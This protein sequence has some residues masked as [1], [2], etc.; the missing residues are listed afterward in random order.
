LGGAKANSISIL[1]AFS[2]VEKLTGKKQL[3]TYVDVNR[4]GDHMCYYSDISKARVHYPGWD[5][6]QSLEETMR[7]I[8]EAWRQRE[9]A[10][11]P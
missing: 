10:L 6:T 7:Q 1:E 4:I 11:R 2:L 3:S 9:S 8:V 5:L